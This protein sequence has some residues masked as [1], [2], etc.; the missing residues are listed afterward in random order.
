M[1]TSDS[2]C[3][4]G[5]IRNVKPIYSLISTSSFS[6]DL[7]PSHHII[8]G[9]S[10]SIIAVWHLKG[11]PGSL[12]YSYSNMSNI[13]SVLSTSIISLFFASVITTASMWYGS[14]FTLSWA[15]WIYTIFVD[16]GYFSE[17]IEGRVT[18]LDI[19]ILNNQSWEQ[20]PDKIIRIIFRSLWTGVTISSIES[21]E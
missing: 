21:V 12:I 8:A 14:V 18:F 1:W 15:F 3:L 5:W 2:K 6:Y 7:I 16:N 10:G 4:L 19:N 9:S 11:T 13:E 20:I 17:D